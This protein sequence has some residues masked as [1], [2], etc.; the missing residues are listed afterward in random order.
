MGLSP[1]ICKAVSNKQEDTDS[2][3]ERITDYRNLCVENTVPVKTVWC[4]SNNEP[5]I[6]PDIKPVLR[7]KK[8]IFKS[9]NKYELRGVQMELRALSPE[10]REGIDRYRRKMEE[11][12]PQKNN[13]G[14]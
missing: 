3:S 4:F 14:V 7:E 9:G 10:I 11:Q 13:S 12:L 1:L 8:R 5:W 6:N 2:F